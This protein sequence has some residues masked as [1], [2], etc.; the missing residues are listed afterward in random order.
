[1]ICQACA[2]ETSRLLVGEWHVLSPDEREQAGTLTD[3]LTEPVTRSLPASWQGPYSLDRR[4]NGRGHPSD[5]V[6]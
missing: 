1:M 4:K 3:I 2:F 6:G 5:R